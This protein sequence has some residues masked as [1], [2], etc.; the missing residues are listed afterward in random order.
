MLTPIPI[1]TNWIMDTGAANASKMAIRMN[2][3]IAILVAH[4]RMDSHQLARTRG[5][6]EVDGFAR[7]EGA[8]LG[9]CAELAGLTLAA[10]RRRRTDTTYQSPIPAS[11]T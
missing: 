10:R 11:P 1:S 9:V 3:P 2:R 6:R 4:V 8:I 5:S 7:P